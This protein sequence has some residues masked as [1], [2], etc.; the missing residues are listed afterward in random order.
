LVIDVG[1][2]NVKLHAS[3]RPEVRK[4]ASGRKLTAGRMVAQ[5]KA[6]TADW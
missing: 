1:G 4:F 6:L 3:G 2:S 5:A